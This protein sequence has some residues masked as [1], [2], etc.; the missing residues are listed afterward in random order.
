MLWDRELPGRGQDLLIGMP[1]A[2]FRP[3]FDPGKINGL[4]RFQG[5]SPA[6]PNSS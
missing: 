6:Q 5:R 1:R 4:T 2:S 3:V